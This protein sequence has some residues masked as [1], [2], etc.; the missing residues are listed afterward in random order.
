MSF[1]CYTAVV[2]FTQSG[3]ASWFKHILFPSTQEKGLGM[4][5]LRNQPS[6]IYM[7]CEL[8]TYQYNFQCSKKEKWK[9]MKQWILNDGRCTRPSTCISRTY[10]PPDHWRQT[11]LARTRESTLWNGRWSLYS[12]AYTNLMEITASTSITLLLLTL[13][14]QNTFHLFSSCKTSTFSNLLLLAFLIL[15]FCFEHICSNQIYILKDYNKCMLRILLIANICRFKT[16]HNVL[17]H[18]PTTDHGT[19]TYPL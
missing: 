19:N 18:M 13:W 3:Y 11:T 5:K 14:S 2:W 17:I 15:H 7:I 6:P 9:G 1:W 4:A 8:S 12:G 16:E 10:I